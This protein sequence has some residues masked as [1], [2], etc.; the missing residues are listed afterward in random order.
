MRAPENPDHLRAC[1]RG[2]LRIY[3]GVAPGAGK[4]WRMLSDAADERTAGADVVVGCVQTHGRPDAEALLAGF[5]SV[6]ACGIGGAEAVDVEGLVRRRPHRV[7]IDDLAQRNP[8]GARHANRWQDIEEILDH[9]IDVHTTLNVHCIDSFQEQLFKLTRLR[10][11][12]TVP[13][14]V[15]ESAAEISLVDLQPDDLLE[16]LYGGKVRLEGPDRALQ[17]L[18]R[19]EVLACLRNFALRVA[20]GHAQSRIQGDAGEAPTAASSAPAKVLVCIGTRSAA[21]GL[22]RAGARIAASLHAHWVVACLEERHSERAPELHRDRMFDALKMAEALGAETVTLSGA[23]LDRQLAELALRR[24]VGHFVHA[25][26]VGRLHRRWRSLARVRTLMRQMPDLDVISISPAHS[27]EA[28]TA[29]PAR[30]RQAWHSARRHARETLLAAFWGGVLVGSVT[31][32]LAALQHPPQ[33]AVPLLVYLI[34]VVLIAAQ[35]G[36]WPAAVTAGAAVLSAD[37]L[38]FAPYDSFAVARTE[39]VITLIVFIVAALVASRVTD[40]LRFE[41]ERARQRELRVRFLYELTRSLGAAQTPEEVAARAA[42]QISDHLPWRARIWIDDAPPA[43]ADHWLPVGSHGHHF[44]TLALTSTAG[45]RRLQPEQRQLLDTAITQIGQTLERIHFAHAARTARLQVETETLR[46]SLLSAIA[47]DFRTPLASILAGASALLDGKGHLSERQ[48]DEL[49]RTILEEGR[50]MIRLANNT[51][52]LARIESGSVKLRRDWYPVEDT[53]GAVITRMRD[54][55]QAHVVETRLPAA[56]ATAQVDEVMVVQ[57]LENLIENALKYT[58]PGTRI[59]VG[60]EEQADQIRFW[61]ADEGPGLVPGD[62]FRIF[63]KFY[64]GP[65]KESHSGVGLGLT[66]CRAIVKAH[67]GEIVARNRPT[68]GAELS[69]TIPHTEPQPQFV[70][71]E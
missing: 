52:E 66:I 17:T 55:L 13:D 11:P 22:V 56:V 41:A 4:T 2:R 71:Q 35:L 39:D 57:V 42:E 63:E 23:H 9:G 28:R 48:R 64:R 3:L 25:R 24:G 69:F 14:A 31:L 43:D 29:V 51:L 46:N 36:F 26:P 20:A 70:P 68:G 5:P 45:T 53:V 60:A 37:Y 50:R 67:G 47:H 38:L 27:D 44:G 12:Q 21:E 59:E 65:G 7:L 8:E 49:V 34:G 33:P 61:V 19:R 16:R 62:E 15:V 30:Q 10:I 6:P 1:A 18:Y 58:L 54:R 32:G 40:N